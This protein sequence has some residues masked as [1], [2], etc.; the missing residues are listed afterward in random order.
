MLR[1][2]KIQKGAENWVVKCRLY[3]IAVKNS[4][5]FLFKKYLNQFIFQFDLYYFFD[6]VICVIVSPFQLST[7]IYF[8]KNAPKRE[9][10]GNDIKI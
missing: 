10:N 8:I 9:I 1:E 5:H 6:L 4:T 3:L 2:P 7:I